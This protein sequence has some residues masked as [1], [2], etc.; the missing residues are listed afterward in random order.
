MMGKSVSVGA[1]VLEVVDKET[2]QSA[3]EDE[4]VEMKAM[5]LKNFSIS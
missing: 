1:P 4:I 2:L 3:L 5:K